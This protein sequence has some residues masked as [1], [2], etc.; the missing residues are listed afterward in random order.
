MVSNGLLGINSSVNEALLS[1]EPP[2]ESNPKKN[3]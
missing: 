3:S 1:F 2:K